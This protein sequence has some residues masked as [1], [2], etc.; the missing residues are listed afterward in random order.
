MISRTNMT[1]PV[2]DA[3]CGGRMFWYDKNNQ[4]AL[5]TDQREVDKGAFQKDWNPHWCVKPNVISDF[6]KMPFADESFS[7]V[8]FDPPHLVNGS[9]K[10]VLNKKYGLLN[11]HTW[12]T[13]LVAGFEEC[14]R[15][16]ANNGVLIFKWNEANIKSSDLI[17]ILPIKPLFGDFTGKTGKTIWMT[18][19][20][21]EG[22]E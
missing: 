1:K 13:D 2:L 9:M 7:L 15:V 21:F 6:R 14:W 3:C 5:F 10:S 12:K 4:L 22:N 18:F 11:K 8:V 17:K 16:L 19:L 20:K